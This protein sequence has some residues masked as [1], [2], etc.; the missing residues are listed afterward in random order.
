[1]I[2]N[3]QHN[4]RLRKGFTMA[5]AIGPSFPAGNEETEAVQSFWL[6]HG[7]ALTE[8]Q[9]AILDSFKNHDGAT[10]LLMDAALRGLLSLI[11]DGF[12]THKIKIEVDDGETA[13]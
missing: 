10:I 3:Q 8:I 2:M 12:K 1:M 9:Q 13:Q 6:A 4:S 5:Q 7:E 11:M